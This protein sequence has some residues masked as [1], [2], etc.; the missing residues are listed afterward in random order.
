MIFKANAS[1]NLAL[2][3]RERGADG[4]HDVDL[5]SVPLDLHDVLEVKALVGSRDTYLTEN[6]PTLICEETELAY[7]AFSEFKKRFKLDRGIGI[8]IF[9]RIPSEAGLGGGYADAAGVIRS[10]CWAY[11]I[12]LDD[13]RV[14]EVCT[15]IGAGVNLALARVAAR[16]R[17]GHEIVETLP[18]L[19][20]RYGVLLVKPK[21]GIDTATI[22][23]NYDMIPP[24]ERYHPDIDALLQGLRDKDE[25]RI[26]ENLGNSLLKPAIEM[27]PE[28]RTILTRMG[29]LGF[30]LYNMSS[31][32]SACFCLSNDRKA[33]KR[34]R[35]EFDREGYATLLTSTVL[36]S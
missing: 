5:I 23:A 30:T 20:L 26:A 11:R 31:S 36:K 1:I 6:D 21:E 12:P 25:E 32:G 33:L 7:R 3:V 9:K 19:D 17:G 13:P 24:E 2:D 29:E 10:I 28:V 18:D 35:D 27:C 14:S 22:Y 15:S 8:K 16:A 34:A 4:Y